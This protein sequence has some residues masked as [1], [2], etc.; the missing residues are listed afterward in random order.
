[1]PVGLK[2]EELERLD[3]LVSL[4]RK[5]LKGEHLFR[6]GEHFNSLFAVKTGTFKTLVNNQD[7]SDQVI[8]FQMTGELLGLDGISTDR[9]DWRA[10]VALSASF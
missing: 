6:T 9:G 5:L 10:H 8:G 4:R 1:M 7:G 2:P 3:K